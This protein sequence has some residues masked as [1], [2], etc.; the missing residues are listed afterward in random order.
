MLNVHE[1]AA[2]VQ[3]DTAL[4]DAARRATT[5]HPGAAARIAKALAL[6]K[7]DAVTD[8]QRLLPRLFRVRSASHTDVVYDVVSNGQTTCTCQDYAQHTWNDPHYLCKHGYAVLL[9]RSLQRDVGFNRMVHAYHMASGEE[10]HARRLV[11]NRAVFH[12]GGHK[13]GFVC[14]AAELCF[15]PPLAPTGRPY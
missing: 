6:V 15:G 10:G 5:A 1:S 2:T 8:C 11:G 7:A 13:H 12:P 4:T 14:S 3:F 9:V